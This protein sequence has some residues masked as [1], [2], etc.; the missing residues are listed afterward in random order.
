MASS[1]DGGL[2]GQRLA[3]ADSPAINQADKLLNKLPAKHNGLSI[4]R[5]PVTALYSRYISPSIHYRLRMPKR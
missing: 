2:S 1:A 3:Q 5:T 4:F